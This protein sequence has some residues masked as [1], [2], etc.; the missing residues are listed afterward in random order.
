M[1]FLGGRLFAIG[2]MCLIKPQMIDMGAEE[3]AL[4]SICTCSGESVQYVRTKHMRT[5]RRHCFSIYWR[6]RCLSYDRINICP[7]QRGIACCLA[8]ACDP[9]L[10]IFLRH[11]IQ[12]RILRY[13]IE[14]ICRDMRFLAAF[15]R[16]WH[17]V[18]GRSLAAGSHACVCV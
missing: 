13:I 4:R 15:C 18:V 14:Q 2:G 8:W 9:G 5:Q 17:D 11:V 3:R 1:C 7:C 12:K 16:N 10:N 6:Y